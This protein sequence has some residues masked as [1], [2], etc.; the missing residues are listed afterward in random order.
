MLNSFFAPFVVN[1]TNILLNSNLGFKIPPG[2]NDFDFIV[3]P[4]PKSTVA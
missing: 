3:S 2:S 4:K 1:Y